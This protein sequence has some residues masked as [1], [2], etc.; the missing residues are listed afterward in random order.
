[1]TWNKKEEE[2]TENKGRHQPSRKEM[3][4]LYRELQQFP[5]KLIGN[6]LVSPF[7]QYLLSLKVISL[8]ETGQF[9]VH[10]PGGHERLSKINALMESLEYYKQEAVFKK[11]PEKRDAFIEKMQ[12]LKAKMHA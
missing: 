12:A 11:H 8:N 2:K 6:T 9:L 10:D 3:V 4:E 5:Q 7:D 1:M